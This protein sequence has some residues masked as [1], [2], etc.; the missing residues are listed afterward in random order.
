ME[1][2]GMSRQRDGLPVVAVVVTLGW[3]ATLWGQPP[4][5]ALRLIAFGDNEGVMARPVDDLVQKNPALPRLMEILQEEDQHTPIDFILHTGDL[6][7][8]DPSPQLFRQALGPFLS[9][10]YPT[11]GG[12]EEFL[13]GK[14]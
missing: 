10:F 13:Q 1:S 11:T 14:Y 5:L 4:E 7:R 2:R 3:V 9:R 8:F 12:D 6:V